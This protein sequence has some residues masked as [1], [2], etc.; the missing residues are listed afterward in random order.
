MVN[1]IQSPYYKLAQEAVKFLGEKLSFDIRRNIK[2][3]QDLI[4]TLDE[5]IIENDD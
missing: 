5:L 4:E 3:N 1:S 2:S